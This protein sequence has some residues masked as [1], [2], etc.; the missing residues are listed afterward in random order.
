MLQVSYSFFNQLGPSEFYIYFITEHVF[1][2][3]FLGFD[4]V[5]RH[6]VLGGHRRSSCSRV[7]SKHI[8][9]VRQVALQST[10]EKKANI[11]LHLHD[12]SVILNLFHLA[13]FALIID[14][15]HGD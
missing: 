13:S 3:G 2:K 8:V 1:K 15:N 11:L 7:G 14:S 9:D 10:A 4:H 6:L 5:F 12:G